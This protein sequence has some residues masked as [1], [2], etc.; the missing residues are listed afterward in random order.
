MGCF[1]ETIPG[2]GAVRHM[3]VLRYELGKIP[4]MSGALGPMQPLAVTGTMTIQLSEADGGT[5]L[6]LT[7][8]V[9]GYLAAG[10][11]TWAAPSDGMLKGQ[12]AHLKDFVEQK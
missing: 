12:M 2:R 8:A 7:Y 4:V 3:E 6:D 10:L 5:K 1:C 9:S 11:N